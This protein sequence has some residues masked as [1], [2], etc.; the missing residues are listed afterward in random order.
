LYGYLYHYAS[1]LNPQ[2]PDPLHDNALQL[3]SV[4]V[5]LS[6]TA[7]LD[8]LWLSAGYVTGLERNRSVGVWHSRLGVLAEVRMGYRG[9]GVSNSFYG[10]SGQ[11]V[12]REHGGELYWGDPLY[13][14]RSYNRSDFSYTFVRSGYVRISATYSL[15]V[16]E[17]WSVGHE[18]MLHLET[19]LDGFQVGRR[20]KGSAG[21][22]LRTEEKEKVE[23]GCLRRMEPA[24]EEEK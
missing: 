6:G 19:I 15:H 3:L 9:F 16:G 1:R 14:Q 2:T 8:E 17:G 18:Q 23:K 13:R 10:G 7:G 5:D 24:G 21:N 22:N 11:Q 20:K 12:F 4:G